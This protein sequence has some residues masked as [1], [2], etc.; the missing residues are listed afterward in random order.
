MQI[1]D[2]NYCRY[3]DNVNVT[4]CDCIL[5][6]GDCVHGP[7]WS[8]S[9]GQWIGAVLLVVICVIFLCFANKYNWWQPQET[10]EQSNLAAVVGE[11]PGQAQTYGTSLADTR[12]GP[13]YAQLTSDDLPQG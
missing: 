13:R 2:D 11:V 10:L 6:T 4:T 1:W 9:T 3:L 5:E 12:F 8:P 7:P